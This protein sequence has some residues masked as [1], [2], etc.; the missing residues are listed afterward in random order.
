M[1]KTGDGQRKGAS[2]GYLI[3]Y[4]PCG[5]RGSWKK[6]DTLTNVEPRRDKG[7]GRRST[8]SHID[9]STPSHPDPGRKKGQSQGNC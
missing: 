3:K 4:V 6:G 1:G 2:D 8:W 7:R 9:I 5:N